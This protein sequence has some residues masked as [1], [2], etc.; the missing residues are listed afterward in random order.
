MTIINQL[1]NSLT[2]QTGNGSFVGSISPNISTPIIDNIFD[3]NGN[4]ILNFNANSLAVNE[5]SINNSSGGN[6]LVINNDG[7][8][9]NIASSIE[10]KGTSRVNIKGSTTNINPASGYVG[11]FVSSV[12]PPGSALSLTNNVFINVTTITLTAGNWNIWGGTAFSLGATTSV[13]DLRTAS[14]LTSMAVGAISN[15]TNG[16]LQR[17]AAFVPGAVTFSFPVPQ[18]LLL[19]TTTTTLYLCARATFSAST[20]SIYGFICAQRSY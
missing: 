12:I 17:M 20:M 13:T 11:E 6:S 3:S 15:S 19:L 18:G 14:S 8:D 4:I 9:T 1:G 2:D 7:I 5:F 16:V 10:S